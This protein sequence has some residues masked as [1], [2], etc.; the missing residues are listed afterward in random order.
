MSAA[1]ALFWRDVW[2]PIWPN[3]AASPIVGG[4]VLASHILR[5]R[6]ARARHAELLAASRGGDA[7]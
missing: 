2:T 1:W 6:A 7:R 4:F 5:E 3:V